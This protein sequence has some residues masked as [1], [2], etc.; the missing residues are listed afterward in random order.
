MA[1][2]T[3]A[4][5]QNRKSVAARHS[6]YL[7]PQPECQWGVR[8]GSLHPRRLFR[9][10]CARSRSKKRFNQTEQEASGGPFPG[11]INY[12]RSHDRTGQMSLQPKSRKKY[13]SGS[14]QCPF[15]FREPIEGWI[16]GAQNV[17]LQRS[18][19][20]KR[21]YGHCLQF[22]TLFQL[23]RPTGPPVSTCR[24]AQGCARNA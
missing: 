2:G 9:A 15:F 12:G 1:L 14:P 7:V 22:I 24:Y 18:R 21:S 4:R 19:K 20:R 11:R 5:L 23:V 16:G 17:P 10:V 8:R 13:L 3:G 6:S